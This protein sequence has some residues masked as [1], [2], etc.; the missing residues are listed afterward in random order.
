MALAPV[1]AS[2][3]IGGFASGIVQG[4]IKA[5]V[6]FGVGFAMYQGIDLVLN[7]I[8]TA[9]AFNLS[10]LPSQLVGVLGLLKVDK[11]LNVLASAFAVRLVLK[12]VT[13]GVFKKLEIRE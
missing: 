13:N 11:C 10:S 6:S 2:V 4:I 9:I 5:L 8:L 12:G 1:L 7:Q 3:L